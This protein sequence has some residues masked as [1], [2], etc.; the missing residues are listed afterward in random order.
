MTLAANSILNTQTFEQSVMV[1][2]LATQL[3]NLSEADHVCD[4]LHGPTFGPE[5][6][7]LL[8]M[9][10]TALAR[11]IAWR[12]TSLNSG[13]MLFIDGEYQLVHAFASVV[14]GSFLMAG[15]IYRR[16]RQVL[17]SSL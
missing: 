9:D 3:S 10:I 4:A 14:D 13:D 15:Q 8:G 17:Q 1:A 6:G 7:E 2:T 16:L 11:R 12:G 5:L